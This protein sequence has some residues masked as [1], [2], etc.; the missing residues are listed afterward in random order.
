MYQHP[1]TMLQLAQERLAHYRSQAAI[2]RLLRQ[3][4]QRLRGTRI[5]AQKPVIANCSPACC[6]LGV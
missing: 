1:E 5:E 6:P 4:G 2:D 3:V